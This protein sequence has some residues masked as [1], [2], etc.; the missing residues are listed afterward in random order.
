MMESLSPVVPLLLAGFGWGQRRYIGQGAL[1]RE[2]VSIGAR[3]VVGM[4]AVVLHDVPAD[5]IWAG[6][7]AHELGVCSRRVPLLDGRTST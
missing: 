7:P 4:G 3:A 6:A 1:V 5:Q 2:N